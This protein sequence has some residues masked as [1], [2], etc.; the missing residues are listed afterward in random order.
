MRKIMSVNATC[1]TCQSRLV[2]SIPRNI[3]VIIVDNLFLQRR[4]TVGFRGLRDGIMLIKIVLRRICTGGD[5]SKRPGVE[6]EMSN[7]GKPESTSC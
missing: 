3:V 5:K 2:Q 7:V 4:D 1:S 6:I